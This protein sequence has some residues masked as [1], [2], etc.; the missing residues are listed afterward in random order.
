M[1]RARLIIALWAVG[2]RAALNSFP[3]LQQRLRGLSQ[4][5][6]AQISNSNAR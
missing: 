3:N 5:R 2:G 6:C 1:K 4:E